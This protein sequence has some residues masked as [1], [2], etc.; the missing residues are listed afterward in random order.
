MINELIQLKENQIVTTSLLVAEKFNKNHY[1][2]L[3]KID[4]LILDIEENAILPSPQLFE[5]S[6]YKTSQNKTLTMYYINRDGFTLLVM[7]FTGKEA[8]EWKLKYIQAFNEMEKRLHSKRLPDNRLEIAKI[9]ARTSKTGVEAIMR[10]YP[11][12]FT[13]QTETSLLERIS[14]ANTSYQK[15]LEDFG[16]TKDW[17]EEFPT[18]D[19]YNNYMRYCVEN[20]IRGMGKKI[21]YATLESDFGLT[22]KQRAN[23]YRYFV[24]A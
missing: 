8:L 6:E 24:S 23:G 3:R 5:K 22:K 15:W 20:H 17:I 16:I 7:G 12:Y 18:S 1:D 2:V 11:E 13:S 10:L 14:D 4:S 9:L 21:F 19:I